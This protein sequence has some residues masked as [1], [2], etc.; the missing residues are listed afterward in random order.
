MEFSPDRM[1]F[2]VK[3]N[4]KEYKVIPNQGVTGWYRIN[5]HNYVH[6]DG[7]RWSHVKKSP[8]TSNLLNT[9][10]YKLE[11]INPFEEDYLI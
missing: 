6:W 7:M 8:D 5:K 1:E 3:K 2:Y 9:N 11:E 10:N 4:N